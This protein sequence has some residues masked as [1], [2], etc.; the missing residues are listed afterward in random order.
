MELKDFDFSGIPK[1]DRE[2]M[3]INQQQYIRAHQQ[4]RTYQ[5]IVNNPK[6]SPKDV[7]KANKRLN[8]AWRA[9]ADVVS[10]PELFAGYVPRENIKSFTEGLYGYS[11]SFLE[12]NQ[13]DPEGL[14][15]T[16]SILHHED[17]LKQLFMAINHPDP[18]VRYR[19]IQGIRQSRGKD[20][21]STL[22]NLSDVDTATHPIYHKSRVTGKTDYKNKES[23]IVG[24]DPDATV[25]ERVAA[26]G[27]SMDIQGE[28]TAAA[29]QDPTVIKRQ[30][31]MLED[32]IE[33]P[34]GPE[35]LDQHGNPFKT[36]E[37]TAEG[38]Q[39]VRN[40]GVQYK[41]VVEAGGGKIF[42]KL[43]KIGL[44]AAAGG[45]LLSGLGAKAAEQEYQEN[46]NI[47]TDIQRR[48]AQT[49]LA[50]DVVSTTATAA[51]PVT[52]GTSLAVTGLAEIVSFT[53]GAANM[54]I[55]IIKNTR[56]QEEIQASREKV[57]A[58]QAA[59]RAR[60]PSL[61]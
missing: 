61:N 19:T 15:G 47:V 60:R 1:R 41:P 29:E 3:E 55:D 34:G 43:I 38:I 31:S 33:T 26:A 24:L 11:K 7:Q 23:T 39:A 17:G 18:V 46:P 51:A 32:I 52:G 27:R 14:A 45:T 21:G 42:T 6:S 36:S 5:E 35:I 49:E 30:A 50:A 44:P 25:E 53:A 37:R 58:Q 10:T 56:S 4:I 2:L 9:L 13:L 28:I 12:A 40:L 48:L 22:I 16:K 54:T 20:I 59:R 8:N 57:K